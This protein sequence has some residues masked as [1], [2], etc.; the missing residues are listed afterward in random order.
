MLNLDGR[1][2]IDSF[3]YKDHSSLTSLGSPTAV[4]SIADIFRFKRLL[5]KGAY[6]SSHAYRNLIAVFELRFFN[7]RRWSR[8]VSW[9]S[10]KTALTLLRDEIA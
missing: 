10:G 4:G 3:R 2:A 5:P 1:T 8:T 7:R 6:R 9:L